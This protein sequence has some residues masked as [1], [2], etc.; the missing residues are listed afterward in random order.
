M[1]WNV[2]P[3]QLLGICSIYSGGDCPRVLSP[4]MN[5]YRHFALFYIVVSEV[6]MQ[7]CMEMLELAT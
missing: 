6:G 1:N 5:R 4:H 7:A 2:C 3:A